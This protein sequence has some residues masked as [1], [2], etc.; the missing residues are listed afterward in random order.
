MTNMRRRSQIK[1][2]I[3][4][5][6]LIIL[7]VL[8]TVPGF[9]SIFGIKPMLLFPLAITIA[10]FEQPFSSGIFGLVCGMFTDAAADYLMGFNAMIFMIACIVISLIHTN[11]LK[12]KLLDTLFSGCAALILQ[13]GLDYFFYYRIWNLDPDSYLLLHQFLPSS[14]LSLI[15]LIPLHFLIKLIV[16]KFAHDDYDLK[17]ED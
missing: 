7:Y 14:A 1:W 3:Y 15:C 5:A 11:Y 16:T 6:M 10:C 13:K 12:S 4:T 2:I 8:Q 9:L 17:I